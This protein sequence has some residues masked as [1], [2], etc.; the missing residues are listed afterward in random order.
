[1]G[2]FGGVTPFALGELFNACR[3]WLLEKNLRLFEIDNHLWVSFARM[4]TK[5]RHAIGSYPRVN[6]VEPVNLSWDV[7]LLT[8][9]IFSQANLI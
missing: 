9:S 5:G 3:L 6:A 8:L 1:M 7:T 4:C 2:N